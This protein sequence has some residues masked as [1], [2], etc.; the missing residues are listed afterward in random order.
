MTRNSVATHVAFT[1]SRVQMIYYNCGTEPCSKPLVT[2]TCREFLVCPKERTSVI[3]QLLA[4]CDNEM[5]R[6][7]Q[8][9]K[10]PFSH[11]DVMAIFIMLS[12]GGITIHHAGLNKILN[13]EKK[14]IDQLT[15]FGTD[16]LQ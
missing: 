12:L 16:F 2:C 13:E 11:E 4:D 5:R 14:I 8:N 3:C 1:K 9:G 10:P 7:Q 6:Y 15:E